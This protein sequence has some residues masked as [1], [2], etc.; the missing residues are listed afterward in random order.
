[1]H[2]RWYATVPEIPGA[3]SADCATRDDAVAQC[4]DLASIEIR[5]LERLGVDLDL[6][7]EEAIVD[8]PHR[9]SLI[10]ESL[11]PISR[12]MRQVVVQRIDELSDEL[13]RRFAELAPAA[14]DRAS[15]GWTSRMVL[16]H[17]ANGNAGFLTDLEP[18]PLDP[19]DA[20]A[21]ALEQLI[22]GLETIGATPH[23]VERFGFNWEDGRIRWTPRKVARIV[24]RLQS[25]WLAHVESGGPAP[26]RGTGHEDADDDALPIDTDQFAA[27][28]RSDRE[29]QAAA[30]RDPRI[31]M[32]G[33]WYR[34]YRHCL[35][36]WP[37]EVTERWRATRA[38][39]RERLL[40]LDELELALIRIAP[41]GTAT[42]VRQVVGVAIVHLHVHTA[43]IAENALRAPI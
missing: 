34:Y 7:A 21:H 26:I 25:E 24:G 40:A 27:L 17:V 23:V 10:P 33:F 1:M 4:R 15:D 11:L 43:Q 35:D 39:F 36:A 9:P 32:L 6:E 16:D 31:R 38:A 3:A 20:Q 41:N 13:E 19:A 22:V 14:W 12:Q 42:T 5:A 29:L 2:G 37:D 28:R 8:W 18:W 30:K